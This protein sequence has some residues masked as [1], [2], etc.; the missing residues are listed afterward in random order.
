M[1]TNIKAKLI[2]YKMKGEIDDYF[3]KRF[4]IHPKIMKQIEWKALQKTFKR[5]KPTKHKYTKFIHRQYNTMQTCFN[6]NTAKC[7]TCPLCNTEVD[8]DDH[9]PIYKQIDI[10]RF[11]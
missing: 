10:E 3:E 8:D 2:A 9:F 5:N 1:T 4:G 6:W 7:N 11:R